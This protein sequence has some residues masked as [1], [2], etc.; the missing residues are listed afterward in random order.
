MSLYTE[1]YQDSFQVGHY[2]CSGRQA[3]K[4]EQKAP[5]DMVPTVWSPQFAFLQ[6]CVNASGCFGSIQP[7]TP[8]PLHAICSKRSIPEISL[9]V[10]LDNP[11]FERSGYLGSR[12]LPASMIS[13][14][15][16]FPLLSVRWLVS[17]TPLLHCPSCAALGTPICGV[18]GRIEIWW[19]NK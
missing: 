5:L 13:E 18:K 14:E 16:F 19:L 1:M 6:R 8:P 7:P 12:S 17:S 15:I 9:E 10:L 4:T 11:K 2:Q 3:S